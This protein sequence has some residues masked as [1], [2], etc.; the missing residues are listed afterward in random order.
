MRA[1]CSGPFNAAAALAGRRPRRRLASL[2]CSAPGVGGIAGKHAFVSCSAS[3]SS[4]KARTTRCPRRKS[5]PGS[6][7]PRVSEG[8]RA[9]RQ[10]GGSGLYAR[11]GGRRLHH[12]DC[13]VE[14]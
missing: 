11:F 9:R 6:S 3:V 4:S 8:R 12:R 1:A 7:T 2:T 14:A 13:D 5:W 10:S